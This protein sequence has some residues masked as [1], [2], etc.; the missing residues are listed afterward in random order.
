MTMK[1]RT[2][3]A[4]A[5]AGAAPVPLAGRRAWGQA[6]AVRIGYT[7]SATGPYAVGAGITQ[8]PNYTLW[9][10]QVNA[11]GGLAV[12]G[13]GR[14][15]VELVGIDDR[16]EIETAVRFY[17]KLA[18]DDKV[19]LMLPPW[20][21]AMNFAIAPV[22]SKH[23]YPLIGPTAISGKFK[24]LAIPY[25]YTMLVQPEGQ[26]QAV[27]ALLKDLK[28]QGKI[29]KVAVA[30]VND[31]FGI[32]LHGATSPAFKAAGL[33]VVDT[34][35]YPLGVKDLSPLLKG[36]K[37]A[38]AD[39]F[40]GLTYPPDNILVTGQAKE[41]DWNPNVFFTGVGTAFPFY[42]DRFKG[43]EGVMGIAGWNS[44]VKFPGAKEYY[45][46]HVKKHQKEPDRWASAFA[47]ASLQIL[48]RCVAEVGLD[49]P[50]IKAMLD[51]T[52]FQTVAGP[53]KFT[54]GEN[55]ATPG[56]VGQWQKGEFE[57]IWPR[58][59]ATGQAVTPKPAWA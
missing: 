9:Q 45:D 40:V 4:T 11:R 34:K 35:S 37:A 52:E 42:R 13:G 15:P 19:D 24:E 32:E 53:V 43:A 5:A 38:G 56:M 6:R 22:A 23:G 14:R 20:G 7:L 41:V 59:G 58:S 47:Y 36:F 48:E 50:K 8:A 30:Y 46:A 55:V 26:M 16:S 29:S 39:C 54:K 3:L 28:A 17:E 25:F 2:F 49:R 18:S 31:L 12:A 27:A 51:A 57:L 1:R 10:E 21:S 44:K 33:E